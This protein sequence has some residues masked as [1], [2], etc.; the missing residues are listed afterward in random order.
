MEKYWHWI[1]EIVENVVEYWRDL[2]RYVCSCGMSVS[3][4]QHL[5]RL[6]GEIILT[7]TIKE[8]FLRLGKDAEHY[9][10]LYTQ[11]QWKGKSAQLEQFSSPQEAKQYR[12]RRLIDVPDPF[13]CHRNWVEH[14]WGPFRDC[15]DSFS[16]GVK[17]I[18]T[19][20]LYKTDRMK[21][22]VRRVIERREGLR[23]IINKYRGR[24][25]YPEGWIPFEPL[26]GECLTIGQHEILSV[27]LDDYV[28]EYI[29][30]SCGA[31]G[32]SRMEDGKLNW[33]VE[34]AALWALLDVNFEPYGKDHATPGGSRDSCAEIVEKIFERKPPFGFPYEWVGW[35]VDGK[36][37]GDMGSSDFLGVTP[38]EWLEIA[39]P[40]VLRYLYLKNKPMKRVIIDFS[41]VP[42]L[43]EAY[44]QAERVYYGAERVPQ[45]KEEFE[46]RRSYE[47][48]QLRV[49]P[50]VLPF[51]LRYAH[52]VTL[53]Q[54]LPKENL[55]ENAIEKLRATGLL[56]V[57][58]SEID[59]IRIERRLMEA[60]AW[61][62]KYAPERFKLKILDGVPVTLKRQLTEEEKRALRI[63]ADRLD[64]KEFT[65]SELENILYRI[66]KEEAGLGSRRFFELIYQ[67]LIGQKQGPRLASFILLIDRDLLLQRLR[68]AYQ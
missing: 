20:D 21:N 58:P 53:V 39:E 6:R 57:E 62:K 18:F 61:L 28:V 5:G 31:K 38:A 7:N 65:E 42:E 33:R 64:E 40:E 59:K 55:V 24:K 44:D 45:E 14:Y 1:D 30:S 8:E 29:C 67:I 50:K 60:E 41:R 13:G 36:D 37:M 47:L 17:P 10:V 52:A 32:I 43:V 15:L 51:Q 46:M 22:L 56:G 26:C 25:P 48:S 19:T 54:L 34:W 2:D 12:G 35:S 11:D 68:E 63:L 66:A 3:G 27:N 16:I 9:L 23:Q 49:P 4:L